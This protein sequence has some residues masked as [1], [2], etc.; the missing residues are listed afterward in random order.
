MTRRML[1]ASTLAFASEGPVSWLAL[2]GS[3]ETIDWPNAAQPRSV[4]S[5][6][7]PF[8]AFAYLSTHREAPA[9][10]CLG[11]RAGCWK[12]QGHGRQDIVSALANSC[13]AYFLEMT[14]GVN[15]AALDLT[16]LRFGLSP[17][18]R[19]WSSRRLIGLDEGWPQEP[20]AIARAFAGLAR[21]SADQPV[22]TVL[23]GMLRCSLSGTA[24]AV[25]LPCFAK[26]GT[27]RCSHVPGGDGDGYALGMYPVDRPRS[28]VLLMRHNTTGANAARDLKPLLERSIL[29]GA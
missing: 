13:N 6:L 9:I 17:P 10:E 1:L 20:M 18:A 16:C 12:L 22:Q 29:V 3:A 2:H 11:R 28:V 5:L 7:K 14:A 27:A 21:D 19:S 24:Q 15:R 26:T 4:G 8:L 23:S 25:G